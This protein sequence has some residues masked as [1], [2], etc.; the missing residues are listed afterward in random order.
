MKIIW[1]PIAIEDLAE[2]RTYITRDNPAAADRVILAIRTA[3][4]RL[5]NFPHLG[6]PGRVDRTRE[7]VVA[8]TPYIVAYAVVGGQVMILSVLHSARK[9][10]ESF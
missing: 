3:V 4:S 6:R 7:L 2:A 5:G 10:P 1:R 8:G 9:W